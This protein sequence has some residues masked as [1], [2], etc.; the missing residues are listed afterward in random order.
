MATEK[1]TTELYFEWW[2]DELKSNGFVK[3]YIREPQS[4]LVRDSIPVCYNQHYK[5]KEIIVRN[6]NLFPAITYT[7]DYLVIFDK[8]LL[9]KLFGY[10]KKS[11][12]DNTYFLEDFNSEDLKPG[13]VYSETLFYSSKKIETGE[14]AGHYI[15]Y[16]DV[17]PPSAVLQFVGN[18]QSSRDFPTKSRMIFERYGV[19]I[20][21]VIPVGQKTDLFA[22]TFLP[23]RFKY[24]DKSGQLRKLKDYQK[25]AKT[26]NEYLKSKNLK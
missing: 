6:F 10:I 24:T 1:N 7:P 12:L 4:I 22:K 16:F 9:N 18:L 15:I 3:H 11:E 21:K 13:N 20:N 2:L 8:S 23:E 19:F 17:K 26:I 14:H 5:K 25:S